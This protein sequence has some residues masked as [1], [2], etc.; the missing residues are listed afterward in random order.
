MASSK[1][2][3]RFGGQGLEDRGGKTILLPG[4]TRRR[5]Q[6]LLTFASPDNEEVKAVVSEAVRLRC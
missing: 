6:A 3:G 5:T 1:Q 4:E 2:H